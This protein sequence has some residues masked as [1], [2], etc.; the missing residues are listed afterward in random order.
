M[1]AHTVLD[2]IDEAPHPPGPGPHWE[3]SWSFDFVAADGLLAGYA[4]LAVR[5]ADGR[6]WWWAAVVGQGRPY[7]L[8]R[9]HDVDPPRPPGLEIRAPGLWAEAYCEQPF[10]HWSV[11]LEAFAVAFDDPQ[12]AVGDERGLPLPLGFDLGWEPDAPEPEV[13]GPGSYGQAC[14]VHG[15]VLVGRERLAV[16]GTGRRAHRWGE[17]DWWQG[18]GP[19]GPG[20]AL[21]RLDGRG[22]VEWPEPLYQAP[23]LVPGP[24]GRTARLA[25]ALC[26][27]PGGGL[28]WFEKLSG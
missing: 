20:E 18:S 27:A 15:E 12:D 19:G 3:E 26:R 25:R 14:A 21:V 28:A 23:V 11:G 16:D 22:M 4:R 6:A 17:R 7:V 10:E 5:P 24:G 9:E 8:V 1:M 2:A 13:D